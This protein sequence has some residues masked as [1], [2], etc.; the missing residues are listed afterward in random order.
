MLYIFLLVC[1]FSVLSLVLTI[2]FISLSVNNITHI[3]TGTGRAPKFM[4]RMAK[5][6]VAIS[7]FECLC[8]LNMFAPV[9]R[10]GFQWNS[11]TP[12]LSLALIE[13]LIHWSFLC[14]TF[15]FG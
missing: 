11:F 4:F 6:H 7:G 1:Y 12:S 2:L 5:K 3:R 9:P 10:D 8:R 15:F 14:F 13:T